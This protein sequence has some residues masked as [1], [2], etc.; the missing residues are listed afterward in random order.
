MGIQWETAVLTHL[1]ILTG[2][3]KTGEPWA[4]TGVIIFRED[5]ASMLAERLCCV[6]MAVWKS[7]PFVLFTAVGLLC[8]YLLEKRRRNR[9]EYW[10]KG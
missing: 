1:P 6:G 5:R 2:T 4:D 10:R 3:E 7:A 8:V 9:A